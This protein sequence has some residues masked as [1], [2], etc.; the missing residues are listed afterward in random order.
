MFVSGPELIFKKSMEV[1][2]FYVYDKNEMWL[3]YA[4][5]RRMHN[6]ED[7]LAIN[8]AWKWAF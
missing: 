2:F 3:K 8:T 6:A 7:I 1:A 4:Q 5:N